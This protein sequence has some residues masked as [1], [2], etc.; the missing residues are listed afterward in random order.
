MGMEFTCSQE[1][2]K[3]SSKQKNSSEESVV[4]VRITLCLS[5]RSNKMGR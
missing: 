1:F 3:H 4:H 2:G 5:D